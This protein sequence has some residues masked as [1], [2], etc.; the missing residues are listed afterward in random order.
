MAARVRRVSAKT[1]AAIYASTSIALLALGLLVAL[2]LQ[3]P[4]LGWVGFAVVCAI[5]VSLAVATIAFP[6]MRVNP[7][8]PAVARGRASGYLS[9]PTSIAVHR[10][11]GRRFTRA[12]PARS[13]SISWFR[14]TSRICTT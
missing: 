4:L 6:R 12:S 8:R 10:G 13:R 11:S 7:Q 1:N 9:S 5:V 3:P 14:C 2:L